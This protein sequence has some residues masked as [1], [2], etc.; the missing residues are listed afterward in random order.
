M[1]VQFVRK[2]DEKTILAATPTLV[3]RADMFPCDKD[4]NILGP[5]ARLPITAVNISAAAERVSKAMK[6][7]LEE[8]EMIVAGKDL[9][10]DEPVTPEN[11]I[12]TGGDPVEVPSAE[13]PI[14]PDGPEPVEMPDKRPSLSQWT[15]P[16]IFK[17]AVEDFG[18]ER[19]MA[20][21]M[22]ANTMTKGQMMVIYNQLQ[23]EDDL[24]ATQQ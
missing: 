12:A 13:T 19:V 4:G 7:T 9:D 5:P 21:E 20:L 24:A 17:F 3:A 8:A 18:Q 23:A 2:K 14:D 10:H 6:C 11:R 15:K 22:D 16:H 1:Q